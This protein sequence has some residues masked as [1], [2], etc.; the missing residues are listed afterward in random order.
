MG[1]PDPWGFAQFFVWVYLRGQLPGRSPY[2][3]STRNYGHHMDSAT[4]RLSEDTGFVISCDGYCE[5]QY[6]DPK[7]PRK[8]GQWSEITTV[9]PLRPK[10]MMDASTEHLTTHQDIAYLCFL[11]TLQ[12]FAR[13]LEKMDLIDKIPWGKF[14]CHH[15]QKGPDG[16]PL[17]LKASSLANIAKKKL[18]ASGKHPDSR[19]D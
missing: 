19:G 14:W 6:L 12:H 15:Q 8:V 2:G 11:R 16:L 17:C 3:P 13:V 7:G 9:R 1:P 18:A 5:V 10:M 4:C